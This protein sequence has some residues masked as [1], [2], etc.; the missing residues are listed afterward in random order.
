MTKEEIVEKVLKGMSKHKDIRRFGTGESWDCSCG[1]E[2]YSYGEIGDFQEDKHHLIINAIELAYDLTRAE[3]EKE[4]KE[5]VNR[6]IDTVR[7]EARAETLAKVITGCPDLGNHMWSLETDMRT[8][9][10]QGCGKI[11]AALSE[12]KKG[13]NHE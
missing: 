5:F 8:I 6:T 12:K 7:K 3:C 9:S 13:E 2:G 10:C 4:L 1:A 11:L